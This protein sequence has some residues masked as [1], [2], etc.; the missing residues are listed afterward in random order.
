MLCLCSNFSFRC[1]VLY[2]VIA[3]SDNAIFC[4]HRY[5]YY[6][7]T[8]PGI[9][10]EF[11]AIIMIMKN[12]NWNYTQVVYSTD[13]YNE[14]DVMF[15]R[16]LAAEAG[17]C[18][19][20]SY[21]F[22]S[23][24]KMNVLSQHSTVRPVVLLLSA[25]KH[26]DFLVALSVSNTRSRNDFIATAT[27]SNNN[28]I[29]AGLESIAHGFISIDIK[30]SDLTQFYNDLATRRVNTYMDNPWFEEW[31]EESFACYVGDNPRGFTTPCNTAASITSAP[32]FRRDLRVVHVINAVYAI[33]HGLNR[34]LAK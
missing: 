23:D 2:M 15:F 10:D 24:Y 8:V 22:D 32:G 20:A 19:V 4:G 9:E 11:R 1:L 17:I 12:Y 5:K 7:K 30:Y 29:T 33:A 18:V 21:N 13:A 6:L 28:E 27:L 26:R 34:V 16:H 14:D 3:V 31:F 25:D